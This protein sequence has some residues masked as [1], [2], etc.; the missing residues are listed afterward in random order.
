M[1]TSITLDDDIHELASI[2]AN[3]RGI[4][5]GAALGELIRKAQTPPHSSSSAIRTTRD[6][7]PVFRSRGRLLTS[8]MVK[9][10][11][12]DDRE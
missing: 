8:E 1:R 4:T 11:Q 7:F 12:E 5:L 10:A 6:G 3:A 2:Y 9:E